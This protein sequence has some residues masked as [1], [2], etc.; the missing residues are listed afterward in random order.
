MDAISQYKV[1]HLFL[2]VGTNPLP[3]Y[4]AAC[5]LIKDRQQSCIFFVFSDGTSEPCTA[6]KEVL[7]KY[8]FEN[9]T[10]VK[11]EEA[12]AINIRNQIEQHARDLKGLVGINYTG[13]TKVMAVHAYQVFD[14]L[15][16][17]DGCNLN[18]QYSYLDARTLS[19][20]MEGTGIEKMEII[21][22]LGSYVS[23]TIQ[24]IMEL[25]GLNKLKQQMSDTT[26]WPTVVSELVEIHADEEKAK[27]WRSWC[28]ATLRRDDRPDK[29]LSP[30][31]L[32]LLNTN[33]F[34]F[35]TVSKAFQREYPDR[36]MPLTFA[37]LAQSSPFRKVSDELAKWFDGVWLEHYVFRQLLPLKQ[38]GQIQDLWMTI[39]P[40]LRTG[41]DPPDFEFDVA[42]VRG[43]QLFALTCTSSSDPKL[44]KSK[45]LEA[46]IRAEQLGGSEA[47]VALICCVDF[48]DNLRDQVSQLLHQRRL[49]VFGRQHLRDLEKYLGEWIEEASKGK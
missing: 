9:F 31:K 14:E 34:P 17:L 43:Y 48:P 29:F 42:C 20:R 6:L 36:S 23:I 28:Q 39:N 8:G 30:S 3:N 47:R 33:S 2:L 49:R 13:G 38:D 10:D 12:N 32:K 5:L 16:K 1:D 44:C 11:V 7:R 26:I 35:D 40:Y 45:L 15:S 18:V 22:D 21:E 24:E 37:E 46:I 25:H 41:D 19:M 4:V 27:T